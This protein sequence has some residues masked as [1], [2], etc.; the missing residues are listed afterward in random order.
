MIAGDGV[1][2][3]PRTE[4]I[5]KNGNVVHRRERQHSNVLDE[6]GSSS[7]D[8]IQSDYYNDFIGFTEDPIVGIGASGERHGKG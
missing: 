6:A 7:Q 2:G 8:P 3:A 5:D 4:G 1:S